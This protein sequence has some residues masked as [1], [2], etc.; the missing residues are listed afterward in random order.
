MPKWLKIRIFEEKVNSMTK[1]HFSNDVLS[2]SGITYSVNNHQQP[3]W[4]KKVQ[5]I[6]GLLIAKPNIPVR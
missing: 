2:L 5:V 1:Q 6:S 3:K 4:K